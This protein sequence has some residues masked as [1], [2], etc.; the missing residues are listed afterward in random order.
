MSGTRSEFLVSSSA[1]SPSFISCPQYTHHL[2]FYSFSRPTHDSMT[3]MI[4]SSSSN[5]SFRSISPACTNGMDVQCILYFTF[6]FHPCNIAILYIYC[7]LGGA[8]AAH[9]SM[10]VFAI[11]SNHL[12]LVA[13]MFQKHIPL[14]V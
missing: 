2:V 8:V 10:Y 7:T 5:I 1:S 12:A 13:N 11:A 14:T 6:H 4:L 3:L 9:R